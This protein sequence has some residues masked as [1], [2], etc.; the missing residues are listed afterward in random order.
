M[1]YYVVADPHG[2]Y[3][4]LR[5]ALEEAGFFEDNEPH[6]LIVCG[7]VLDRGE[8]SAEIVDF[9]LELASKDMLILVKGNHEDL[10]VQCLMDIAKGYV[11]DIASGCSYH[12]RNR[13]WHSILQLTKMKEKTAVDFSGSL[14]TK[15]RN[16]RFYRE[17]LPLCRDYY[18]TDN[19]VFCHGWIP[20]INNGDKYSPIFE[21]D[22]DW[23]NADLTRW[24]E[25][26]WY[27]GMQLACENGIKE[28][29]KTIVCGHWHTSFG[30]NKY[31]GKGTYRGDADDLTPFYADGIIALDG[32]TVRSKRVNCIV[33]ED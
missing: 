1:K 30:H 27:N 14:V 13:T 25:A 11:V 18:E 28:P 5:Q 31:E 29:G 32:C 26:R 20:V 2:F 21:Y 3:L 15:A 7:D 6:K 17:L 12:Y 33:I 22:P 16:T 8:E 4:Y 19:Y 23:R 10:F 9:L 24:R